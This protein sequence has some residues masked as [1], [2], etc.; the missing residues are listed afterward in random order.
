M[1]LDAASAVPAPGQAVGAPSR[2][3]PLAGKRGDR[4]PLAPSQQSRWA[5]EEQC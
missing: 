2:T 1:T 3:A 4:E 5:N